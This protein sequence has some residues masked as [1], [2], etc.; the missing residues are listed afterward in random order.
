MANYYLTGPPKQ[1]VLFP[2]PNEDPSL[3]FQLW[4]KAL[5]PLNPNQSHFHD[6]IVLACSLKW[7]VVWVYH[8][9]VPRS[10]ELGLVKWGDLF[11]PLSH[12]L[13]HLYSVLL[14][15]DFH[16]EAKH[17]TKLLSAIWQINIFNAWSMHE[18]FSN[19]SCPKQYVCI[20][21]KHSDHCAL[22]CSKRKFPVHTRHPH[23]TLHDWLAMALH[24]RFP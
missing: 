7:S 24:H 21:C 6:L 23:S 2:M 17:P 15:V 14:S 8:Y 5:K 11:Q 10:I 16:K 13:S 3:D 4:M 20:I 12:F 9:K 22:A 18:D 1:A 19:S